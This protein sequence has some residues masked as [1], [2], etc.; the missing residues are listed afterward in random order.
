VKFSPD[1]DFDIL[2][3]WNELFENEEGN[4]AHMGEDLSPSRRLRTSHS[5]GRPFSTRSSP[6]SQ[7]DPSYRNDPFL[8]SS[9]VPRV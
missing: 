5:D 2:T 7:P 8:G 9:A 3:F 6:G 4:V 1:G